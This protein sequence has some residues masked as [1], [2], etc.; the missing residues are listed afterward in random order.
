MNNLRQNKIT[1]C[2]FRTLGR[3]INNETKNIDHSPAH[4]MRYIMV[5]RA[6]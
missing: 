5:A 4:C 1:N 2:T 6:E 3:P